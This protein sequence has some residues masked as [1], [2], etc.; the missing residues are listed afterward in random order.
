MSTTTVSA[1]PTLFSTVHS[2]VV[3]RVS[4]SSVIVSVV[5]GAFGIGAFLTSMRM[6][7]ASSTM[8][9]LCLTGG[10]ILLLVALFRLFWRSK[11]WVYIPTGSVTKEGSCFF[12]VCDLQA[13]NTTMER[14]SFQSTN[15]VQVKTNG[16]V[17]MDYM[18]SRDKKF[19]AAQLFRFV[20]YTYE[21]VSSVFYFTGNDANAF[22]QNLETRKF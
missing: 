3:K 5:I 16:N 7:D 20:P 22:V 18:I 14:K 13:L 17:R 12:D 19:V 10:T 11:E 8:S 15:E 6:S 21:P 2:D 4:A 1:D 9:M